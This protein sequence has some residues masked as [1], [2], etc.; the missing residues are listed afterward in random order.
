MTDDTPTV[1]KPAE[2]V[3]PAPAC[4]FENARNSVVITAQTV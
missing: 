1:E 3:Q 2:G 4:D